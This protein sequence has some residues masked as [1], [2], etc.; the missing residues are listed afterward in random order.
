MDV[1]ITEFVRGAFGIAATAHEACAGRRTVAARRTDIISGTGDAGIGTNA[2]VT[3]DAGD[4]LAENTDGI[5]G[6]G[7]VRPTFLRQ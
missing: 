5:L 2:A 1:Q 3:L 4:A 6:T 7:N